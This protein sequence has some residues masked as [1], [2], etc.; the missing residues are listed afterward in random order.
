MNKTFTLSSVGQNPENFSCSLSKTEFIPP[1]HQ[2]ALLN[3]NMDTHTGTNH[4]YT[5]PEI[6]YKFHDVIMGGGQRLHKQL[7]TPVL[8]TDGNYAD[9]VQESLS[10]GGIFYYFKSNNGVATLENPGIRYIGNNRQPD[11]NWS[12]Q[13]NFSTSNTPPSIDWNGSVFTK[14]TSIYNFSNY[15]GIEDRD[16]VVQISNSS[17]QNISGT[18]WLKIK[19]YGVIDM[20]SNTTTTTIDHTGTLDTS[21]NPMVINWSNGSVW[22]ATTPPTIISSVP[23]QTSGLLGIFGEGNLPTIGAA[24][25]MVIHTPLGGNKNTWTNYIKEITHTSTGYIEKLFVPNSQLPRAEFIVSIDN[26]PIENHISNNIFQGIVPSVYTHHNRFDNEADESIVPHHLIYHKL[27]NK[28][29]LRIGKIDVSIRDNI[30]NDIL[31]TN[32]FSNP[33]NLTLHIKPI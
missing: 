7:E 19:S 21:V 1:N 30:T 28:G 17:N 27:N 13:N 33:T 6:G 4:H 31:H 25:Q 22:T 8:M 14:N 24:N 12:W 11:A 9:F 20:Y 26:L 18:V 5:A 29:H 15:T 23:N 16:L 32:T 2:I 3:L 10:N